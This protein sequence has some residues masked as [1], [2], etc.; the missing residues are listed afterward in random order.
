MAEVE[1]F[2]GAVVRQPSTFGLFRGPKAL[3]GNKSKR[4]GSILRLGRTDVHSDHFPHQLRHRILLVVI[5]NQRAIGASIDRPTR[6]ARNPSPILLLLRRGVVAVPDEEGVGMLLSAFSLG[7]ARPLAGGLRD[8]ALPHRPVRHDA[9]TEFGTPH[10]VVGGREGRFDEDFVRSPNPGLELPALALRRAD[11]DVVAIVDDFEVGQIPQ[12]GAVYEK[13]NADAA[14]GPV[15][16][17]VPSALRRGGRR[18]VPFPSHRAPTNDFGKTQRIQLPRSDSPSSRPGIGSDH[19]SYCFGFRRAIRFAPAAPAAGASASASRSTSPDASAGPFLRSTSTPSSESGALPPLF[20]DLPVRSDEVRRTRSGGEAVVA[21]NEPPSRRTGTTPGFPPSASLRNRT[22]TTR[23][24]LT[25]KGPKAFF[26][27]FVVGEEEAPDAGSRANRSLREA[28]DSPF[29]FSLVRAS[30]VGARSGRASPPPS[31]GG[32][33]APPIVAAFPS[34]S[35]LE[36]CSSDNLVASSDFVASS[37]ESDRWIIDAS[38]AASSRLVIFFFFFFFLFFPP[39]WGASVAPSNAALSF[40]STADVRSPLV[41]SDRRAADS[42]PAEDSARRFFFFFCFFSSLRASRAPSSRSPQADSSSRSEEG[43]R[44]VA[45]GSAADRASVDENPPPVFVAS[46][47]SVIDASYAAAS[48]RFF[49]F[50]FVFFARSSPGPSH[51]L[52]SSGSREASSALSHGGAG[53]A[54]CVSASRPDLLAVFP[55]ASSPVGDASSAD[56]V[57]RRF[58]FFS[59]F[60]PFASVLRSPPSRSPQGSREASSPRSRERAAASARS[61][62]KFSSDAPAEFLRRGTSDEDVP[63]SSRSRARL[64][65]PGVAASGASLPPSPP[66]RGRGRD[67]SRSVPRDRGR[68]RG[69]AGARPPPCDDARS[70]R[71]SGASAATSGDL[72]RGG[73]GSSSVDERNADAAAAGEPRETR[74][75]SSG[76]RRSLRVRGDTS[77]AGARRRSPSGSVRAPR[78]AGR[79]SDESVPSRPGLSSCGDGELSSEAR[80]PEPFPS[81]SPPSRGSLAKRGAKFLRPSPSE[82]RPSAAGGRPL[83]DVL[84][85]SPA[86]PPKNRPDDSKADVRG[87]VV[88]PSL[89]PSAVDASLR[90]GSS[91]SCAAN[92]SSSSLRATVFVRGGPH[93]DLFR[94]VAA[95]LVASALVPSTSEGGRKRALGGEAETA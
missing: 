55:L 6:S 26:R 54:R 23:P 72:R 66:P 57:L 27:R 41:E 31:K 7:L 35:A 30:S 12:G 78:N 83:R 45:P 94:G 47:G 39:S 13:A 84:R 91:S 69:I 90:N 58:F 73:G 82:I 56:S 38:S 2:E 86:S 44:S 80:S 16:T 11:R 85:D 17:T 95:S 53:S 87:V 32:A 8:H 40:G 22:A 37:S 74:R 36:P 77:G 9:G 5:S 52:F 33:S 34:G 51:P 61:V 89:P 79:P 50:V 15:E 24:T 1:Q 71:P 92:G 64:R 18:E 67:S 65:R 4:G 70:P 25:R 28:P 14:I 88:R 46:D 21:R 42:S 3:D 60:F 75:G 29:R 19:T 20:N 76:V 68:F 43:A 49:F 59:F 62:L 63:P 93:P 10:L 48:R 81:S